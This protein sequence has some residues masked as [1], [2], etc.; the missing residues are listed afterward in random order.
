M[1][2][3]I[4]VGVMAFNYQG[5]AGWFLQDSTDRHSIDTSSPV[6]D[7][8][9]SIS[10]TFFPNTVNG[11]FGQCFPSST[12]IPLDDHPITFGAWIWASQPAKVAAPYMSYTVGGQSVTDEFVHIDVDTTPRFFS[13]SSTI[14]AYATRGCLNIHPPVAENQQMKIFYDQFLLVQGSFTNSQP[15]Y[16][17]SKIKWDG[18][19][20]A[21]LI[22]NGSFEESSPQLRPWVEKLGY[23][24]PFI[25]GHLSM[26]V[27]TILIP[28]TFGW[29]FRDSMGLMFHTFW[30]DIA[31]DKVV[32]PGAY[33]QIILFIF[34]LL[35]ITGFAVMCW[36]ERKNL[37]LDF[38][39]LFIL[40]I[41]LIMGATIIRGIAN[42]LDVDAL[43][44]W[45]R[46]FMPAIFPI[47]LILCAGWLE[48]YQILSKFIYPLSH[49]GMAIYV[50]L[51][52]TLMFSSII[53]AMDTFYPQWINFISLIILI[54]TIL[55]FFK[56][57][58]LVTKRG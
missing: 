32:L 47:G 41:I 45:A 26:F 2:G 33:T 56:I 25:A 14:P 3:I 55:G 17:N 35:G 18:K 7:G 36:K 20:V 12:I 23:K 29:Y 9:I 37:R 52:L 57:V 43:L 39:L 10:E 4:A 30:G 40:S 54:F 53:A 28:K 8:K 19:Q 42:V 15:V 22:Q 48:W 34:S 27:S 13:F 6:P 1:I 11:R 51:L 5:R 50:T 58:S 21:N 16:S 24:V 38:S 46:Y 44:S 31:G 49:Y